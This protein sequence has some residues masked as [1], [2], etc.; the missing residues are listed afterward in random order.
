MPPASPVTKVRFWPVV[1]TGLLAGLL[2][3]LLLGALIIKFSSPLILRAEKYESHHGEGASGSGR[4]RNVGTVLGSAVIGTVY[5]LMLSTVF[6]LTTK[7]RMTK[8]LARGLG[9]GVVAYL[10]ISFI[11]SMAFLPNP[12]GVEAKAAAEVR[13]AWWLA[14]IVAEGLGI[15]MYAFVTRRL[16]TWRPLLRRLMGLAG[17]TALTAIPFLL[18]P[19]NQLR[20]TLIPMRLLLNFRL[21]SLAILL[22]F[23]LA[24]GAS[25]GWLYGRLSSE[26]QYS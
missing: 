2:A 15:A 12:P 18:G 25:V 19:P 3:G 10:V 20:E 11:P 16:Q 5:G 23:W 21:T 7:R 26:V 17:F 13:Q 6:A 22:V 4:Q 1:V 9:Y 14:I 8:H 24:L